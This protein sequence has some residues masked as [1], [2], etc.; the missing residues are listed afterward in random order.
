MTNSLTREP[1]EIKKD[2]IDDRCRIFQMQ[3]RARLLLNY[4]DEL[5]NKADKL[6]AERELK[7]KSDME[8]IALIVK[9]IGKNNE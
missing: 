7:K 2:T 3:D 6:K 1:T 9:S 5:Q 8:D 4:N